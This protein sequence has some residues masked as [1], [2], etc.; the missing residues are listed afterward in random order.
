MT[1]LARPIAVAAAAVA[2]ALTSAC[3]VLHGGRTAAHEAPAGATLAA[4][5]GEAA[6]H[7]APGSLAAAYA[8]AGHEGGHGALFEDHALD[9]A[10][11]RSVMYAVHLASYRSDAAAARGWRVLTEAAPEA[12]AGLTA[13]V[14]V[15]DLGGERGVYRRLKAGPFASRADAEARC[16]S[17]QAAGYFC[18]AVDFTG[19]RVAG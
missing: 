5:Y 9:A 1:L 15:V 17:L 14:E 10:E 16:A 7:A 3:G 12:L 4:A 6:P 2:A 11:A 18:Q 13:R 8:A 19:E